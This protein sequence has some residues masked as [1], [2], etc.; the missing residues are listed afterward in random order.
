[1]PFDFKKEFKEQYAPKHT[2]M[3][4]TMPKAKYVAIKGKGNPNE[5]DGDYTKAVQT[6]YTVAYTL[7][8]L[9][10]ALIKSKISL[11]MSCHL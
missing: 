4:L 6:L 5:I 9:I 3:V 10:K 11:I 2:P 7:K 1:M 8:C